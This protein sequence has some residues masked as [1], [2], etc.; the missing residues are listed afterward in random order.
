MMFFDDVAMWCHSTMW[1]DA[2]FWHLSRKTPRS[3]QRTRL[4]FGP[5]TVWAQDVRQDA[6]QGLALND[7]LAV[8]LFQI[9]PRD[10]LQAHLAVTCRHRESCERDL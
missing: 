1:A 10:T 7:E 3:S 2:L 5:P 4:C 6:A 8:Q 9:L